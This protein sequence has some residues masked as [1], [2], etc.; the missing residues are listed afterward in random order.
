MNAVDTHQKR[1]HDEIAAVEKEIQS[2]NQQVAALNQRLEGL[3]RAVELFK[4]EQSAIVELLR[5]STPLGE[6][7]FGDAPSASAARTQNARAHRN[8]TPLQS[9]SGRVTQKVR[10]KTNTVAA[11]PAAR[12]AVRN[13]GLKR[14]D[15]IA[16]VLKRHRELSVRELI[17]ALD[18]EFSWKSSESSV[19]AYLYTNQNRFM[20]TKP[21]RAANRPVTWSLK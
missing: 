9:Q 2:H 17:A 8:A 6:G 4:S 12:K 15:M 13:G 18:K 14:I 7:L 11:H 20:H 21:D 10:D 3:K 1:L 5:T 19:T 16:A